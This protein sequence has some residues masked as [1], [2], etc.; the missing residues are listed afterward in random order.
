MVDISEKSLA[1][2]SYNCQLIN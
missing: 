1:I 2:S